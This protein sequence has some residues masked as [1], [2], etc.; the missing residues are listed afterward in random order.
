MIL[1]WLVT[2]GTGYIG[3]A[4]VR[5]LNERT[6]HE[7]CVAD[8]LTYAG[9]L[10]SLARVCGSNRY[11]FE[12]ADIGDGP[13]RRT[14]RAN[15][16]PHLKPRQSTLATILRKEVVSSLLAALSRQTS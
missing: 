2:G 5:L 10:A 15:T 3:S 7:V 12:Q 4:V 14:D 11:R 6:D 16:L 9:N 1:K 8:K 13:Q